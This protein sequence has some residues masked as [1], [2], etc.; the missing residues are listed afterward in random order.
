MTPDEYHGKYKEL[1]RMPFRIKLKPID[2]IRLK[3]GETEIP[4]II[5]N[6]NG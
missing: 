2:M 6:D 1:I 3:S 5:K 4:R